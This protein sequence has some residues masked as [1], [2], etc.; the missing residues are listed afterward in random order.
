MKFHLTDDQRTTLMAVL[1]E[2]PEATH[3]GIAEVFEARTGRRICRSVLQKIRDQGGYRARPN[4]GHL[5]DAQRSVLTGLIDAAGEGTSYREIAARFWVA[6]RR[7]ITPQSVRYHLCHVLGRPGLGHGRVGRP[8]R[9][10]EI[11]P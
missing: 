3:R 7:A 8:K 10:E 9:A 11:R 1:A 2:Y 6:T 4:N 5:T